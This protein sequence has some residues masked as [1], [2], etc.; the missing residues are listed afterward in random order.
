VV[1][2]STNEIEDTIDFSNEWIHNS[3]NYC[4]VPHIHLF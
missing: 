3:F 4:Y 1:N 2:S